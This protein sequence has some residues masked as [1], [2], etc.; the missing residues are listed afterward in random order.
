MANYVLALDQGTT[1]SRAILFDNEQNIL[2]IRQHELSQ[3]YPRE[4]W[5][6]EDP[7]EIWSTQ[8]AAMLEALAAA[9]V[10]PAD[11]SAI[12]ITNQRETTILW[13]KATGRPVYNA[14]VWQCRRTADIVDSLVRQGLTD[15]IRN[16]TGLV[17]DAYFPEQKSSG[18]WTMSK[19]RGKKPRAAR[20]CSARWI[21]GWYGS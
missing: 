21:P 18:F 6:E 19:A 2:S 4:G 15:H 17:L 9:D 1:S 8:Y 7:M 16:T 11:V 5:V 20:F 13:D 10:S 12:G 14:I 3:H